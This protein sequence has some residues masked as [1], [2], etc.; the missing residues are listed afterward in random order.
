MEDS[1][2]SVEQ[3]IK[4]HSE[5]NTQQGPQLSLQ[6]TDCIKI[7]PWEY[8][9]DKIKR[10]LTKLQNKVSD[11]GINE[12]ANTPIPEYENLEYWKFM[13]NTDPQQGKELITKR[14]MELNNLRTK[15]QNELDTFISTNYC[16]ITAYKLPPQCNRIKSIDMTI[17]T[18]VKLIN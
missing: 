13:L 17:N 9:I 11:H 6:E 5:E 15:H 10:T 14:I 12:I 8:E 1:G 16:G 4:M 7:P 18:L 2:L 3:D